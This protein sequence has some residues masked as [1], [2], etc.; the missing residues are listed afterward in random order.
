[1]KKLMP[2]PV[3][4]SD[5]LLLAQMGYFVEHKDGIPVRVIPMTKQHQ[6]ACS[7]EE[8]I[9]DI[10]KAFRNLTRKIRGKLPKGVRADESKQR[11]YPLP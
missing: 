6:I 3:K 8:V 5:Y 7:A 10:R 4:L 2:L 1:M 9:R 11:H